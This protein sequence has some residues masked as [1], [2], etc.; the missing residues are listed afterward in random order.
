MALLDE[1]AVV[2]EVSIHAPREGCDYNMHRLVRLHLGF[3]FTHPGR[4]AT[5]RAQGARAE[6]P[7]V[8]IHAPREGCDA[9]FVVLWWYLTSFQF[10]HPGRGATPSRH[11]GVY[12]RIQFQ[13]THPG[14][15]ATSR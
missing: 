8:S 4:G 5:A 15:G 9:F 2:I 14:R 3:Q 6:R 10:T 1:R 13:F 11:P 12:D 7:C